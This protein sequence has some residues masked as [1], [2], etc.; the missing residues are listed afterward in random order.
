[1][2][3]GF[4]SFLTIRDVDGIFKKHFNDGSIVIDVSGSSYQWINGS[5]Q[6]TLPTY[7]IEPVNKRYDWCSNCGKSNDEHPWIS[8]SLKSKLLK[9]NGYFVRCGCCYEGCCC[10]ESGYCVHCCLYSWSLQISNDNITWTT[11]HRVEKDGGMRICVEKSYKLDKEYTAK[12]VRLL[13]DEPCPGDP[14]C[15][16]IN[17][18]ELLGESIP[19]NSSPSSEDN[20]SF[21]DDEQDISIIGHISKNIIRE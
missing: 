5:K 10:E 8:F 21:N 9:I 1:M 11:V 12:Y 13:Q 3:F 6:L 16:A 14:P 18:F 19:D 20:L 7:A 2:I 15:L 17:K 4:L